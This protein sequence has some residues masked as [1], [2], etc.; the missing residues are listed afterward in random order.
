MGIFAAISD[1]WSEVAAWLVEFIPT[2]T[3]IF[4]T[5]AADG[6]EGSLTFLGVLAVISLAISVFFL[7]MGLIQ[8][9]LHLRG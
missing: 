6:T 5:P 3:A 1:V 4:W 9:F 7:I 2:I 8:N